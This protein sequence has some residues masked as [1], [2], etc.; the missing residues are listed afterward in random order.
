MYYSWFSVLS[1][2]VEDRNRNFFQCRN[3]EAQGT[4]HYYAV[5][6]DFSAVLGVEQEA[7]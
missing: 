4:A 5:A 2:T 3:T 7:Y 1:S 6:C